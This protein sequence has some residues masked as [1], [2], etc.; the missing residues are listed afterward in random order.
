MSAKHTHGPW[1]W[2]AFDKGSLKHHVLWGDH[3]C[4]PIVL[5]AVRRGMQAADFRLRDHTHCIMVPMFGAPDDHPDKALIAD[6]PAMALAL[7]LLGRG[8]ARFEPATNEFCFNGT[9]YSRPRDGN[10][11]YHNWTRLLDT[12]GWKVAY[13][14]LDAARKAVM[15]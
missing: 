1:A 12:I 5:D 3:G 4:R 13:E 14:A 7:E 15:A 2:R 10:G 8:L 6:A 11:W 9:R